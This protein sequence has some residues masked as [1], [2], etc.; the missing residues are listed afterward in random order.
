[1]KNIFFCVGEKSF[2]LA[3]CKAPADANSQPYLLDVK[4]S[5]LAR[6]ASYLEAEKSDDMIRIFQIYHKHLNGKLR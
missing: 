3:H 6:S 5:I 2:R 1:M 4:K